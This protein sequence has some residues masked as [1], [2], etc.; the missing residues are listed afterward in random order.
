MDAE[1]FQRRRR[2]FGA[3]ADLYDSIRPSY[4]PEAV[5]WLLGDAPRRVVDL[6]A[7]TGI[8]SRVLASLG[9]DVTAVEPDDGMR[10]KL[11]AASPGVTAAPGSA[12]SIPLP[13]ES[14]DAAVA[15]Q[16]YHWFDQ[17]AAHDEIARVLRRGGVFGPIWNVRD[18]SVEW[19]AELTRMVEP[20]AGTGALEDVE[21]GVGRRFGPVEKAEFRHS[22]LHT[23]ETL[24]ALVKSRSYFLTADDATKERLERSVRE[25]ARPL[26]EP[27]ALPYVT[28]V[29]RAVRL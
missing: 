13:D 25:L 23:A 2:S 19:V 10:A 17:D 12:E 5:R 14:V 15:A 26:P 4:P 6:G 29:Y 22:T 8:F 18:E 3:A 28:V 9:H 27:F 20:E 7:G 11:A 1:L 21:R 24:V 16:S